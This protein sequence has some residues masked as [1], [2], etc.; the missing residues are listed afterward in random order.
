MYYPK[1]QVKTGLYT[2]GDEYVIKG[3]DDFYVG[4][5]Y[6]TSDGKKFA[7]LS[8]NVNENLYELILPP[9][10]TDDEEDYNPNSNKIRVA[11]YEDD[12]DP[13]LDY[14]NLNEDL[15]NSVEIEKYFNL[16][17]TSPD[18][19]R[20]AP[21]SYTPNIIVDNNFNFL[22]FFAKKTNEYYFLEIDKETFDKFNNNDVT[23]AIDLYE[24]T[25]FIFNTANKSSNLTQASLIEKNQK[26]YGF[27]Q[28][29]ERLIS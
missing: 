1:S 20:F 24:V 12:P 13:V 3:T 10:M 21:K 18:S 9:K 11:F 6:E 27:S 5:Y 26:W 4:N 16:P 14:D 2:N 28:F 19:D 15:L 17:K 7:G 25:S 22:R 8:P 23:A 29:I